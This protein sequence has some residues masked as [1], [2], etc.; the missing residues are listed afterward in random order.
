MRGRVKKENNEGIGKKKKK[1]RRKN[2]LKKREK[3]LGIRAEDFEASS[4]GANVKGV[5]TGS[6]SCVCGL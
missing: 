6:V 1:K 4:V 3:D 2:N 5:A